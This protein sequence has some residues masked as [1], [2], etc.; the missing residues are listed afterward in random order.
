MDKK[1]IVIASAIL[2]NACAYN[3]VIDTAGRSGRYNSD[4]AKLITNDIQHCKT[5]ADTNTN[6][7]IDYTKQLVNFYFS[8]ITI[9]II[10]AREL[11]YN[12]LVKEC[13]KG[14]GHS[15]LK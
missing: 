14:R 10:P 7:T 12:A 1:I 9:G 13:L 2:L 6:R 5:I 4:Q 15:V 8:S 3:P 11:E